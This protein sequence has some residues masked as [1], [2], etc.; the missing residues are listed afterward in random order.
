MRTSLGENHQPARAPS[1]PGLDKVLKLNAFPSIG[2]HG[3]VL[4]PAR[5]L[6]PSATQ[7]LPKQPCS[8][9]LSAR[10][11]C[12]QPS[13]GP[14]RPFAGFWPATSSHCSIAARGREQ[15]AYLIATCDPAALRRRTSTSGPNSLLAQP[16]S[17]WGCRQGDTPRCMPDG[18][19]HMQQTGS[20]T[21]CGLHQLCTSFASFPS[22]ASPSR[23]AQGIVETLAWNVLR[24]GSPSTWTPTAG[25]VVAST[26]PWLRPGLTA[27]Q[28]NLDRPIARPSIQLDSSTARSV[29]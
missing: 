24:P 20:T 19:P 9:L 12:G 17:S 1:L 6:G 3:G 21:R 22:F 15:Y 7:R 8:S 29:R 13:A 11:L 10:K 28:S 2:E 26:R 27:T 16:P 5:F 14:R 23:Y 4:I 25:F 18:R